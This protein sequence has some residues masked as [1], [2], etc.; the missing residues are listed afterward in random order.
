M[1][2]EFQYFK[3]AL[4]IIELETSSYIH[5]CITADVSEASV[6]HDDRIVYIFTDKESAERMF[7]TIDI[8]KFFNET[9]VRYDVLHA[10]LKLTK[11]YIEDNEP[12]E[13]YELIKRKD[14]LDP[15]LKELL[16]DKNINGGH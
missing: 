5:D 16:N 15:A 10:V 3:I 4:Y 6:V 8:Y 7:D 9:E 11:W 1:K 2:I 13:D 12:A 14:I